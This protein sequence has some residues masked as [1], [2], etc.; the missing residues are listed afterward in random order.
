MAAI[1]ICSDFGAPQNKVSHCFHCPKNQ[2]NHNLSER[3]Q[4]TDGNIHGNK[5]ELELSDLNFRAVIIKMI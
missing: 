5:S 2:E 4:Q 3:R 1:T